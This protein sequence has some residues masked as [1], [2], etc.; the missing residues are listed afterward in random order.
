MSSG[1]FL[2][3]SHSPPGVPYEDVVVE[4][5]RNSGAVVKS[6]DFNFIL[7]PQRPTLPDTQP[8]DWLH[9]NAMYYD[10]A[11]HSMVISARSQSAVAKIDLNTGAV[12]WILGNH[13]YW[14]ESLQ[15]FLLKPVDANGNEIDVSGIDFWNYGQHAIQK[16]FN[17]NLLLY[18]NGDYRGYYDDPT[19]SPFSYTRFTEYKINEQL[20]TVKLVW[21]FDYDKT[22]FTPFTGYVQELPQTN[23]RLGA[24]MWISANTPKIV[25][26]NAN[27]QII[28]EATLKPTLNTNY[29][30]T[31]KVDVYSGIN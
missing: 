26:L 3:P 1:N 24:Y 7:D 2:I 16:T 17:G 20:K 18:D 28:F 31:Y 27:D 10:E 8:G 29:Y 25:E 9:V 13:A 4:I 21:Q 5:D 14:N 6:W 11:D 15:P 19:V 30:R 12:K 22:V 23:S